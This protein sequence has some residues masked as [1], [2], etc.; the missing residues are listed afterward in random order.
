MLLH[1]RTTFS[2]YGF[3]VSYVLASN[4]SGYPADTENLSGISLRSG[5]FYLSKAKKIIL[6][7]MTPP[8]NGSLCRYIQRGLFIFVE[9]ASQKT[10]SPVPIK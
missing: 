3:L 8:Q 2:E 5:L 10:G 9:S 6:C 7:R 4:V 1:A